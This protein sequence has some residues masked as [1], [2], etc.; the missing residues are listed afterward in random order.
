L[1]VSTRLTGRKP[2]PGQG[3][4]TIGCGQSH[5]RRVTGRFQQP[6]PRRR[7]WQAGPVHPR[8]GDAAIRCSDDNGKRLRGAT[9]AGLRLAGPQPRGRQRQRC[10]LGIRRRGRTGALP[11]IAGLRGLLRDDDSIAKQPC[12]GLGAGEFDKAGGGVS[13]QVTT[14]L[15]QF[16]ALDLGPR[17][18]L[19]A[20]EH[21]LATPLQHTGEADRGFQPV[22]SGELAVAGDV[23]HLGLQG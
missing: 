2:N 12:V 23:L 15:I 14:L 5:Q 6:R 22:G 19:G 18:R 9:A 1:Q 7:R 4:I 17:Q 21:R 13:Q 3:Q 8:C 11:L 10:A 16:H 20:A